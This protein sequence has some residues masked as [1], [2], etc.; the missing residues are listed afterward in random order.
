MQWIINHDS[1]FLSSREEM[2]SSK[3]IAAALQ[4]VFASIQRVSNTPTLRVINLERRKDRMAAFMAQMVQESVMMIK[5]VARFDISS[6]Q[7]ADD[8]DDSMYGCH[9]FDGQGRL[10]EAEQ[11]LSSIVGDNNIDELVATHWRPNDLTPFDKDAPASKDLVRI[12]PSE[13]A[14]ALSHIASW[15]GVLHTLSRLKQDASGGRHARE[16]STYHI[17]RFTHSN[18]TIFSHY[19]VLV[20]QSFRI[21][22]LLCEGSRSVA[23][24]VEM[25]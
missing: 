8:F 4:N 18:S 25:P 3:E 2:T 10:V 9:A 15:R 21:Q 16:T 11:R 12:S 14:C 20:L 5:G 22:I 7:D 1:V 19:H 17:Q 6:N 13:K 24:Q 23:L